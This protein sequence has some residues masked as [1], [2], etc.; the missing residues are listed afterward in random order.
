M[1]FT[2]LLWYASHDSIPLEPHVR[3]TKSP[4]EVQPMLIQ[5]VAW[6]LP[7]QITV[8]LNCVYLNSAY[9]L[10]W[11]IIYRLLILLFLPP[12]IIF[13][14]CELKQKYW[15]SQTSA[16]SSLNCWNFLEEKI[17]AVELKCI[18]HL[19]ISAGDVLFNVSEIVYI[20]CTILYRMWCWLWTLHAVLLVVY[21]HGDEVR[22]IRKS[23]VWLE[24]C[25]PLW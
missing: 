2:C 17:I 21:L 24:K 18:I 6:H 20:L 25:W 11:N 9:I 10:A 19:Y 1:S 22:G 7:C 12:I 5:T 16:M 4:S 3:K 23:V 8:R 15:T 14:I 13:F